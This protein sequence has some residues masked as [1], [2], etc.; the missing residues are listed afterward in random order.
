[1][2]NKIYLFHM[3]I[4]SANHTQELICSLNYC[5]P[6][7]TLGRHS[8][9]TLPMTFFHIPYGKEN[10]E[11]MFGKTAIITLLQDGVVALYHILLCC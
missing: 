6:E 2:N 9:L 5:L 7:S 8:N 10:P 3:V 4:Q 11:I 1:M